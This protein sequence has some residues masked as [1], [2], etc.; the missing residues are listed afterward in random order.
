MVRT[1]TYKGHQIRPHA[2]PVSDSEEGEWEAQVTIRVSLLGDGREQPLR[3][4][5]DRTFAT[6]EDAERYAVHIAMRW[7]DRHGL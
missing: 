3:D 2:V 1:I 4:P 5:D 6:Q 7:V